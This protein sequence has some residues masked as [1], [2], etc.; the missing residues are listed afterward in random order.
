MGVWGVLV[1]C[2]CD[3]HIALNAEGWPETTLSA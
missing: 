1:Y 3:H 2:H